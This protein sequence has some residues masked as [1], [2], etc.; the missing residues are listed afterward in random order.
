MC[1]RRVI[2]N[3]SIQASKE[4]RK[5]SQECEGERLRVC[6]IMTYN[7]HIILN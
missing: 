4:M 6:V 5:Q 3:V 1:V 2:G 7:V